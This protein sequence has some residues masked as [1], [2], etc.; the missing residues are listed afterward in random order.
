M[1]KSAGI[2]A[3]PDMGK[4]FYVQA[5]KSLAANAVTPCFVPVIAHV[6]SDPEPV[7]LIGHGGI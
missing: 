7:A 2:E 6:R 5:A 3:P 4:I 1:A